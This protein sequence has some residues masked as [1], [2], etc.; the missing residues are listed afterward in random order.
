VLA[1]RRTPPR[2][3][4]P[5]RELFRVGYYGPDFRAAGALLEAARYLNR[6]IGAFHE[7]WI[8]GT[9]PLAV[10]FLRDGGLGGQ[11]YLPRGATSSP[12]T[13]YLINRA[14]QR[15]TLSPPARNAQFVRDIDVSEQA[16]VV[17]LFPQEMR[18]PYGQVPVHGTTQPRPPAKVF[19]L[20]E[21]KSLR[22]L[23]RALIEAG[24]L[25]R[26]A[27]EVV[28]VPVLGPDGRPVM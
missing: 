10:A 6:D 7:A 22:S 15:I 19:Y 27:K 26:Q 25:E 5:I 14:G 2:P 23:M 28:E 1:E 21:P 12:Y 24:E 16:D 9:S 8:I 20:R 18:L 4:A 17:L 13:L 11:S 3:A